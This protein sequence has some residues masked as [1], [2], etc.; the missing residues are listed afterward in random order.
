MNGDCIFANCQIVQKMENMQITFSDLLGVCI[1]ITSL[2]SKFLISINLSCIYIL[3]H[4][5]Y[6]SGLI[7]QMFTLK[8]V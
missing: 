1:V 5:F 7:L 6:F 2:E 3:T 8:C 4:Q